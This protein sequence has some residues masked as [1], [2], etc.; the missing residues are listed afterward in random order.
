MNKLVVLIVTVLI[1]LVGSLSAVRAANSTAWWATFVSNRDGAHRFYQMRPD[2]TITKN[3]SGS[4]AYGKGD[5]HS[6]DGEW[7]VFDAYRDGNWEVF[8]RRA[9][10]SSVYNV[11]RNPAIDSKAVWTPD[12]HWLIVESDRDGDRE[13]Y[14]M[15][16]DG[17]DVMNLTN[18]PAFD[19]CVAFSPIV[20]VAWHPGPLLLLALIALLAGSFHKLV[21]NNL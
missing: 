9:D 16:P 6:P 14:R 7:L 20:D 17:S 21:R 3:R 13:L 8:R 12:G 2:G 15:R 11:T 10:G 1:V 18:N 4:I 5:Y 19:C